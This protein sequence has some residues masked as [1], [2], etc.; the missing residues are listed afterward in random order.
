M[1]LYFSHPL[2]WMGI[3]IGVFVKCIDFF[4]ELSFRLF[5]LCLLIANLIYE[6]FDCMNDVEAEQ[7]MWSIR[8]NHRK[9]CDEYNNR[10]AII[11]F[12]FGN[13]D[14]ECLKSLKNTKTSIAKTCGPFSV[15]VRM[16][17]KIPMTFI[18]TIFKETNEIFAGE[19]VL[20]RTIMSIAIPG[21]ILWAIVCYIKSLRR[22]SAALTREQII[23]LRQ[24]FLNSQ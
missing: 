6:L 9:T 14:A 23:Q 11:S 10:N 22:R 20:V 16:I 24:N 15:I 8:D 19:N 2:I 13:N 17:A 7:I 21:F 3:F 1:A 5:F 12:F 4:N 18:G